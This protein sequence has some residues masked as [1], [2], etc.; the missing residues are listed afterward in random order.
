MHTFFRLAAAAAVSFAGAAA[1]AADI[2]VSDPYARAAS[3]SARSGAAFMAITNTGD[4]PDRLVSAASDIAQRVELHTHV[5]DGDGVMRMVH[6]EEGFE[7]APGETVM[8]QRGGKHV[9]FM[10]LT[11]AMAQGDSVEVTLSFER[12][13]D[14][15]VEVPVDLERRP[16]G[17]GHGGG[18]GR[19]SGG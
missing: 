4:A 3:P 9:M 5:A 7:I 1:M 19:G 12:A 2:T 15:V 11:R 8:L 17:M 10:G 13:G 14:V 16:G 6:V 18:M